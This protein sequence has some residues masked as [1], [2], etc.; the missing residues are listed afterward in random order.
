MDTTMMARAAPRRRGKELIPRVSQTRLTTAD[1]HDEQSC[2]YNAYNSCKFEGSAI[3]MMDLLGSLMLSCLYPH[4]WYHWFFPLSGG[5]RQRCFAF[6]P[7]FFPSSSR[8]WPSGVLSLALI[9]A[10]DLTHTH[11]SEGQ[12]GF[13]FWMNYRKTP[14]GE[15]IFC[16]FVTINCQVTKIVMNSGSQLSEL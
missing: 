15:G 11:S 1:C 10:T 5:R 13:P 8:I 12:L 3:I 14:K 16:Q 6:V 2:L 4:H 7:L 9:H